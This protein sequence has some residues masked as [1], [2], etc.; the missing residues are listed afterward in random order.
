MPPQLLTLS[1]PSSE[2]ASLGASL[3]VVLAPSGATPEMKRSSVNRAISR[4]LASCRGRPSIIRLSVL[5]TSESTAFI[6]VDWGLLSEE[7]H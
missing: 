3:A 6:R 5:Q 7:V 4:S 2:D 1:Q